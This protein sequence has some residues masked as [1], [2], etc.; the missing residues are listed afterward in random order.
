[1]LDTNVTVTVENLAPKNG[2]FLSPLWVGFHDGEFDTY[3]VGNAVSPGLTSLAEDG[4]TTGISTELT[5]SIPRAIDRTLMGAKGIDEP[6][7]PGES[8]SQTFSLDR[9]DPNS[10]YLNYAAMVLPSNDAFIA[11]GNP[12]AHEIF[13][14]EGNFIG[15][16]FVVA[17]DRVLDAG[18]E[19][20][21]EN[22]N[23]TAFFGQ[24]EP[25]TGV[26]EEGVVEFHPG[27]APEGRILSS[28]KFANADF[29]AE[30][31]D[32]ARITVTAEEIPSVASVENPLDSLTT[33]KAG[34]DFLIGGDGFDRLN[35][36]DGDDLLDGGEGVTIYLGG[37]GADSFVIHNDALRD[38]IEDFEVG[39]DRIVLADGLAVDE[40][41]I[42]GSS[43]TTI[44]F[45]ED[46]VAVLTDINP[47]E[48]D[49]TNFQEL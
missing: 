37:G 25:N 6:I 28:P 7:D 38:R 11:N 29:T 45:E 21:N 49:L 43:D 22:V 17:G 12:Q 1:M 14:A 19:I 10:R 13:D 26:A 24:T 42:T 40:L 15:A 4:F 8:V 44:S 32:V 47:E 2:I 27:F 41:E 16:D 5:D 35:G 31:Y 30:D 34:N 48:L 39:I 20:N 46:T 9:E 33:A 3:D 36:Q 23:S 18:T